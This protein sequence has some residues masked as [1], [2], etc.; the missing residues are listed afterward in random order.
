MCLFSNKAVIRGALNIRIS[1]T[2]TFPLYSPLKTTKMAFS[3]A[4]L[5]DDT[6]YK[7]SFWCKALA[8]PA[9]IIIL[10]HL[11]DHG[12]TA[13]YVLAKKIPLS[14][15]S[16]SQHIKSLRE[17]G[18]IETYEKYPHT[19]YSL[20]QPACKDLAERIAIFNSTFTKDGQDRND[21]IL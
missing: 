20:N 3:K 15:P 14:R 8:H 12:T 1:Q 10:S 19:Y 4:P 2:P 11:L 13:F 16:I 21:S 6:S 17:A 18:L 7:Q 9:R 5:F